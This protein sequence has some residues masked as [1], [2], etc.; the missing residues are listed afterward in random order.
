[1]PFDYENLN[2]T[3]IESR[4]CKKKIKLISWA[5]EHLKDHPEKLNLN[6]TAMQLFQYFLINK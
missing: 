6:V 3:K 1:M 5:P 2:Y 4:K